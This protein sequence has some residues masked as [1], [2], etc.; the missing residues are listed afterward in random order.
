METAEP[1][2]MSP[3]RYLKMAYLDSGDYP[4]Y[5]AEMKQETLIRHDD[6]AL[7][8]AEAAARGFSSSGANGMFLDQLREQKKYY[9]RGQ[10][11]PVAL[12]ETSALLGSNQGAVEYLQAA[13]AKHGDDVVNIP[14]DHSLQTLRDE[15]GFLNLL[16]KIGFPPR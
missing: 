11:S 6:V 15:P 8:I 12:A 14:F 1:G 10:V 2:F 16:A 3:H 9:A 5:L 13:Y 4:D 7:S